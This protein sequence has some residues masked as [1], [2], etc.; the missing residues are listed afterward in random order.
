MRRYRA[1]G[2]PPVA[3]E[4]GPSLCRDPL[5]SVIR[6]RGSAR[7]FRLD[8]VPASELTALL[9]LAAAPLPA[10][11]PPLNSACVIANALAGLEPGT[12]RFEAPG[13]W[14]LVRPGSLRAQAGYLCLEQALG[15]RAA[16][17]IFFLADLDEALGTLGNR[18][19]RAAQL[20]AG[21]QAGR[22]YLGSYAQGLGATGLTFYDDDVTAFLAPGTRLSPML[23]VAVGVDPG[24]PR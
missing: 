5:E 18:G 19:Y 3:A 9:D 2:K 7:D 14:H 23:C 1:G 4:P 6:R 21:I 10:D 16:A 15:A 11:I 22:V 24:R 17:T 12:Y 20:E 13:R 8:P